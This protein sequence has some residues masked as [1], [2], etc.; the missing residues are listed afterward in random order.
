MLGKNP[1]SRALGAG[2]TRSVMSHP[3][4]NRFSSPRLTL[5][6]ITLIVAPALAT[7]DT[8]IFQGGSLDDLRELSPGL[9][10]DR[11]IIRADLT[12]ETSPDVTISAND[13]VLEPQARI[14]YR[15]GDCS[16]QAPPEVTLLVSS[17]AEIAGDV[18]LGGKSG[19]RTLSGSSCNQCT[20]VRGGALRVMASSL[21]VS[22]G[23]DTTGGFGGFSVIGGGIPSS[24]CSGGSG[25]L[26]EFEAATMDLSGSELE[27]KAGPIGGG[28]G[29]SDTG[30]VS[31][32]ATS[33]AM[34]GGSI[35]AGGELRL[36]IATP[37]AI[38]APF[39][40]HTL[41]ERIA[42]A[43]DNAPPELQIVSPM[44]GDAMSFGAVEVIVQVSDRAT[45]V[46]AVTLSGLGAEE[47]YEGDQVVGGVLEVRY[48]A[49]ESGILTATAQDNKGNEGST[50]V[51]ELEFAGPV[52]LHEGTTAVLRD[53][54]SLGPG[55]PVQI[56][57][58][59][60][61]PHDEDRTI[62]AGS[63][64][65]GPTGRIE[66]EP[67]RER[68]DNRNNRVKAPRLTVS[69]AD[70]AIIRGTLDL[71][72][73]GDQNGDGI[74]G[75]DLNLY[76]QSISV[77][78]TIR[79]AGEDGKR[80]CTGFPAICLRVQ[81]G[82]G[83]RLGLYSRSS[84]RVTGK[85]DVNA[86]TTNNNGSGGFCWDG[87]N[88][89]V[90]AL[91]YQTSANINTAS[92]EADYGTFLG[93]CF[94]G[95]PRNGSPGVAELAYRGG[96]DAPT[97]P[98]IKLTEVEPN[99]N[100]TLAQ[101][102]PYIT[103]SIVSG[104]ITSNDE[105]AYTYPLNDGSVHDVVDIYTIDF[106]PRE[107]TAAPRNM[108]G[109]QLESPANGSRL[110]IL[111]LKP[112]LSVIGGMLADETGEPILVFFE[113]DD[114]L[115]GGY[116]DLAP[117]QYFVAVTR[118]QGTANTSY[119]LTVVAADIPWGP[120]APPPPIPSNPAGDDDG[121]GVRNDSDN[122]PTVA[123]PSQGNRDGDASGNACDTDDDNDGMPD[124]YE[125]EN[126]LDPLDPAD[127]NKDEDGDGAT[128]LQ[129]YDAGT[130]PR[131]PDSRPL[132]DYS[133]LFEIILRDRSG[134]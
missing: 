40:Y 118:A 106:P 34:Q 8:V 81:G 46:Q 99:T 25:G 15:Q 87:G 80:W 3:D 72:G 62:L 73:V 90:V 119:E 130:D 96:G 122:C 94:N 116:P 20:G 27:S 45:G 131:N 123:N 124:V 114:V 75:G 10:F 108:L 111:L 6:A 28:G 125:R 107:D 64:K 22:G 88:G 51:S 48:P 109:L 78:G 21:R 30:D 132:L 33:L 98:A 86:G 36:D 12:L 16:Y 121:D 129:E 68:V 42:G 37:T 56:N 43:A 13:L 134:R 59:L 47:T 1:R 79:S 126:E 18:L 70:E 7:G 23:V 67:Y 2:A 31:L 85:L 39:T 5:V 54:L 58:T 95:D 112:D 91:E 89:G 102:I 44:T 103:R 38:Y 115:G 57:G 41:V 133:W 84:M 49:S 100:E 128:N 77:P 101:P 32:D 93:G 29:A 35:T 17:Q 11:L 110:G 61:I 24:P 53:D 127:A 69:V 19:T 113:N 65:V 60:I 63:F 117:G 82:D 50:S 4:K 66:V 120:P 76:A 97:P 92:I 83:G 55:A 74:S 14:R 104:A 71:T 26:I 105:V 9:N 52:F